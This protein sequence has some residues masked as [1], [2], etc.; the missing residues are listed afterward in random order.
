MTAQVAPNKNGDDRI[1]PVMKVPSAPCVQVLV[2]PKSCNGTA[3]KA[4]AAAI[5]MDRLQ[6]A[7]ATTK[8]KGIAMTA[9]IRNNPRNSSTIHPA[10]ESVHA[11]ICDCKAGGR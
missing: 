5:Q 1:A 7:I 2:S 3:M 10:H 6:R 4:A 8:A 11:A 9:A